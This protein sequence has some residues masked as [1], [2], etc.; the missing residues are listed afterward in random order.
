MRSVTKTA[1][2]HAINNIFFVA[3]L[4]WFVAQ[5]TVFW[6]QLA[7]STEINVALQYFPRTPPPIFEPDVLDIAQDGTDP[8]QTG[9]PI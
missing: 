5:Q 2:P 7:A 3:I 9:M 8:S 6:P 4:I 1:Q